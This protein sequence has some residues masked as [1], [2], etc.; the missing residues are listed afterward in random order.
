M[1]PSAAKEITERANKLEPTLKPLWGGMTVAEM[2]HH[3]NLAI[4]EI[5]EGKPDNAIPTLKQ[6]TLKFLFLKV[7]P[8]F[9]KNAGTPKRFDIKKSQLALA[10]FDLELERFKH[11]VTTFSNHPQSIEV[12][13]PVF[14]K[15]TTRQWGVFTWMH[16]D[17]H[18]RQFKV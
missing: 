10:S 9:P 1:D 4:K 16:L 15:L 7:I 3:C 13:H 12:T 11:L 8:T 17:H 14:G 18:L 5:L 6:R 2:L